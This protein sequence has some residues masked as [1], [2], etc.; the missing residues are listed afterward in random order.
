M[1]A[2]SENSDAASPATA[3]SVFEHGASLNN[4]SNAKPDSVL[5]PTEHLQANPAGVYAQVVSLPAD[6]RRAQAAGIHSF[7]SPEVNHIY[8]EEAASDSRPRLPEYEPLSAE[9]NFVWGNVDGVTFSSAVN[10]A[11]AETV[12]WRRNLFM[13]PSGKAGK[14]FVQEQARLWRAYA[15][16]SALEAVAL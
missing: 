15:T 5:S 2:N 6:V 7:E 16:A 8:A 11:Y 9:A 14:E 1:S 12:H 13:V 3:I 10:A 4:R